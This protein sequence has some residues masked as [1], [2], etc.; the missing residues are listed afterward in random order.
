MTTAEEGRRVVDKLWVDGKL[1]RNLI[2]RDASVM[3]EAFELDGAA[4][5][6]TFFMVGETGIGDDHPLSGEKLSLV[7][8][9]Y[10]AKDFEDAQRIATE[11]LEHEGKGHSVGIHTADLDHARKLAEEMEVV[12]VHVNQAHT[13]GVGGGFDNGMPF[14]LSMGCGTWQGNSISENLNWRCFINVTHLVTT[15]PEDKPSEDELFGGF[16]AKYGK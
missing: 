15:I 13:F 16:W 3:A 6:A 12:R 8:T 1:N 10:R 9:V 2:A 11:I 14:T 7:L 4:R 5:E